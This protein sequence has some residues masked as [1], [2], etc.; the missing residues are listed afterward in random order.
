MNDSTFNAIKFNEVISRVTNAKE[1]VSKIFTM[2]SS[3]CSSAS[4]LFKSEDS[5]LASIFDNVVSTMSLTEGALES[6][7]DEITKNI[8][9]YILDDNGNKQPALDGNK[10]PIT[11]SD[12]LKTYL[13]I[14]IVKNKIQ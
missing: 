12:Y 7:I 3:S 5:N 13:P 2:I 6:I 11:R 4:S 10:N 1:A 14:S 8:G 9:D